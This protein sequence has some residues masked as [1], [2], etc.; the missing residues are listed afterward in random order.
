MYVELFAFILSIILGLLSYF[1]PNLLGNWTF[2]LWALPLA[3]LIIS[4]AIGM[5][6]SP[7][8][9]YIELWKKL[10]KVE[11]SICEKYILQ[12]NEILTSIIEDLSNTNFSILERKAIWKNKNA[13]I[14]HIIRQLSSIKNNNH[15][16]TIEVL[17]MLV[18]SRS[19]F[20]HTLFDEY[21]GVIKKYIGLNIKENI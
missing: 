8:S 4:V 18:D 7:Y 17:K 19:E 5:V 9:I 16:G 10:D 13:S 14:V 3:A 15:D 1:I 21:N 12:M 20:I 6:I 11:N 2:I